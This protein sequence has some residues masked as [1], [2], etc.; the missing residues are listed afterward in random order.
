MQKYDEFEVEIKN[1]H[2]GKYYVRQYFSP[3]SCS[4]LIAVYPFKNDGLKCFRHGT[5]LSFSPTQ[6][7]AIKACITAFKLTGKSIRVAAKEEQ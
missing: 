4:H 3:N 5:R 1:N 6:E 7:K 2:S